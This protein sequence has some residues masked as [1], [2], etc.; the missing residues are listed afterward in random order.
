MHF[1]C[2]YHY[3]CLC[4]CLYVFISM[5]WCGTAIALLLMSWSCRSLELRH[6]CIACMLMCVS[7]WVFLFICVYM[8]YSYIVRQKLIE[9]MLFV[10]L[11]PDSKQ[12]LSYLG[13]MP[14]EYCPAILRMM[15]SS[16]GSSNWWIPLTKTSSR[17][18]WFETPL[19]SLCHHCNAKICWALHLQQTDHWIFMH[20]QIGDN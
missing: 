1:A 3:L 13:W 20:I 5:A 6:G 15:T 9:L 16:N 17:L 10:V 11:V 19:C 12:N 2:T 7:V 8:L 14:I 18:Q 4:I